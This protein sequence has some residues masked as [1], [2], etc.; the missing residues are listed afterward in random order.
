V[1]KKSGERDIPFRIVDEV[2]CVEKRPWYNNSR[3]LFV[4]QKLAVLED[5]HFELRIG[6]YIFVP[7]TNGVKEHWQW[8]RNA[9]IMGA[10]EMNYLISEAVKRDML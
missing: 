7:E 1:F 2:Q 5:N 10:S 6:Y 3:S 9:P 8:Q 4:L